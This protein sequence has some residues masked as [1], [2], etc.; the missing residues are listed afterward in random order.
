MGRATSACRLLNPRQ[1]SVAFR[2]RHG[3]CPA[4]G[5]RRRYCHGDRQSGRLVGWRC[6]FRGTEGCEVREIEREPTG[7]PIA[8]KIETYS[9]TEIAATDYSRFTERETS[10][11][12]ICRRFTS[13]A[14]ERCFDNHF[15]AGVHGF[16]QGP[17]VDVAMS[18]KTKQK[19][20]IAGALSE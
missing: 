11:R 18:L 9:I 20:Q 1:T 10:W 8:S 15:E 5:E 4:R 13:W 17:R 12:I 7:E 16:L 14:F 6:G 2:F 19:K 3:L